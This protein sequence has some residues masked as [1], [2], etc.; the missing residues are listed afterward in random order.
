M[1]KI[2]V[3]P[4]QVG[5]TPAAPAMAMVGIVTEGVVATLT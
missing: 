2:A 4:S 3:S 1:G 5:P